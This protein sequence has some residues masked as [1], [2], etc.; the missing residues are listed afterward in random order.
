M[1]TASASNRGSQALTRAEQIL[2][3][4]SSNNCYCTQG[5]ASLYGGTCTCLAAR[6]LARTFCTA[7]AALRATASCHDQ[8]H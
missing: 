7:S 3:S 4:C 1:Q 6:S 8:S 2:G 5:S